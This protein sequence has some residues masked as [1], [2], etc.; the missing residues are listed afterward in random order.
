MKP[1]Y[2]KVIKEN[3]DVYE[4][5]YLWNKDKRMIQNPPELKN[6][7]EVVRIL[8]ENGIVEFKANLQ[9]KGALFLTD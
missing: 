3:V 5:T 8:K 6:I 4:A 1:E 9:I 7:D 2:I